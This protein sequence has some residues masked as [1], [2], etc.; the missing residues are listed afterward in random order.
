MRVTTGSAKGVKLMTLP[1]RDTRPTADRL[2]QSMFNMIQF[3]VPGRR[4]LELFAGSGQLSVE[5]L[6]RGAVSATLVERSPQAVQVIR[7]NLSRTRFT[8]A[9]QVFRED[10][11][12]FLQRRHRQSYNL[13]L[14]DPPYHGGLAK[15]ALFM[16]PQSGLLAEGCLLLAETEREEGLEGIPGMTLLRRT[17]HGP[18]AVSLLRYDG[19]GKGGL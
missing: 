16:L 18:T 6:S 19:G 15:R 11:F 8:E 10:V 17:E 4:V 5:A 1:G 9:A 2:K 12:D 13:V 7:E 3:E 14:L